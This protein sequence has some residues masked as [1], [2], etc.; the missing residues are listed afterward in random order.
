MHHPCKQAHTGQLR[1]SCH[2]FQPLQKIAS[3]SGIPEMWPLLE[4][5]SRGDG[6]W[7]FGELRW[8]LLNC[9]SKHLKLRQRFFWQWLQ[10][11]YRVTVSFAN[12]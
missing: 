3:G 7:I 2:V 5:G 9:S 4:L 6:Q 10:N 12:L 8:P 1:F 11:N